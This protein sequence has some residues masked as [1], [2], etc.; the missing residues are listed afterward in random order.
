MSKHNDPSPPTPEQ[1][2]DEQEA[3]ARKID[4]MAWASFSFG[5]SDE[6]LCATM[7]HRRDKSL[8]QAA[9]ELGLS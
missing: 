2:V 6:M 4:P 9:K 5:T 8:R 1:I 7:R 3:L